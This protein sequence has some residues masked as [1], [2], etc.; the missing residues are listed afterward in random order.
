MKIESACLRMF[1]FISVISPGHLIARP[2]P[3]K[4][5]LEIKLFGKP[6][7]IPNF[8]TSSLNNSLKGSTNSS[9]IFFGSPPTLWCDFIVSDGPPVKLTLS[10]TSG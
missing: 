10:I 4:G 7:S 8:L 5:C 2:G 3:G 9:C 6:N 1:S